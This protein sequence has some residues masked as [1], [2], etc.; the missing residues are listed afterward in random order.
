MLGMRVVHCNGR[1]LVADII[2]LSRCYAH[3]IVI[4]SLRFYSRLAFAQQTE[5]KAPASRRAESANPRVS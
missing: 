2:G 1:P 3:A 5:R 4:R